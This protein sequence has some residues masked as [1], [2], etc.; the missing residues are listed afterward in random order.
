MTGERGAQQHARAPASAAGRVHRLQR[1]LGAALLAGREPIRARRLAGRLVGESSRHAR[2]DG[3]VGPNNN[4][5][6]LVRRRRRI[7]SALVQRERAPH[8]PRNLLLAGV[9]SHV[10]R[11]L[12][13][14]STRP[15]GSLGVGKK[16][17]EQSQL[18]VAQSALAQL[19]KFIA[20][21]NC[22]A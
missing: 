5:A 8:R 20:L 13:C 1:D 6:G 16:F 22:C 11:G 4:A 18:L 7:R 14:G 12:D 9:Q 17:H 19:N 21:A 15:G 3:I 10:H 2:I